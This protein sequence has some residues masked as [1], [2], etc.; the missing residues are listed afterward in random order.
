MACLPTRPMG[1]RLRTGQPVILPKWPTRFRIRAGHEIIPRGEGSGAYEIRP[2][3]AR[4][5]S[6]ESSRRPWSYLVS[7]ARQGAGRPF[8]TVV[9]LKCAPMEVV[10]VSGST[11]LSN[12]IGS[13]QGGQLLRGKILE[14]ASLLFQAGLEPQGD[15]M[16]L[17]RIDSPGELGQLE[18]TEVAQAL[19]LSIELQFYHQDGLLEFGMGLGG[20][21]E[22]ERLIASSQTVLVIAG[23]QAKADQGGSNPARANERLLRHDHLGG[24]FRVWLPR[25]QACRARPICL[26][27]SGRARHA[28]LIGFPSGIKQP[29][30]QDSPPV[31]TRDRQ[32]SYDPP[33][34]SF[35]T[36]R[37]TR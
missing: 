14:I 8:S 11:S 15:L 36:L 10:P 2:V 7:L 19:P 27:S 16:Q 22:N 32:R 33:R 20:A 30:A 6:E 12:E 37:A 9:P 25:G 26:E 3:A 17:G 21:A 31:A 24:A 13:K 29:P 34:H 18:R 1:T 35:A 28:I 4:P 23:V 5:D